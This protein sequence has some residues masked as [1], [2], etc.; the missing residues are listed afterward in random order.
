MAEAFVNKTFADA[1][2]AITSFKVTPTGGNEQPLGLLPNM[3]HAVGLGSSNGS[4][5][6]TNSAESPTAI[7]RSAI[8]PTSSMEVG[9][10]DIIQHAAQQSAPRR[11]PYKAPSSTGD[12]AAGFSYAKAVPPQWNLSRQKGAS[13]NNNK[14]PQI[15]TRNSTHKNGPDTSSEPEPA[16]T[17]PPITSISKTTDAPTDTPPTLN[18]SIATAEASVP[19]KTK[20]ES[21]PRESEPAMDHNSPS[22]KSFTIATTISQLSS[23]PT[24]ASPKHPERVAKDTVMQET[25][26]EQQP[27]QLPEIGVEQ[28]P[29]QLPHLTEAFSPPESGNRVAT[30]KQQVLN[31]PMRMPKPSTPKKPR[32]FKSRSKVTKSPR[33]SHV[34]NKARPR[35]DLDDLTS[36][37]AVT[38]EDLLQVLLTRYSCDKQ[39][40][41]QMRANHATEIHELETLSHSLWQRLQKC[42]QEAQD[43]ETELSG[44]RAREPKFNSQIKKLTNYVKGLTNDQHGLRDS[45]MTMQRMHSAV[46]ESKQEIVKSLE[47]VR[48]VVS[49]VDKRTVNA[50][51][52]ARQELS[53]LA[54]IVQDQESQLQKDAELLQYER[55]RSQRLEIEVGK[56]NT[57]QQH[58]MHTLAGHANLVS[59]NMKNVLVNLQEVQ[60]VRK[61]ESLDVVKIALGQ[62]LGLLDELRQ[63]SHVKPEHFSGFEDS[64]KAIAH[65]YVFPFRQRYIFPKML[66]GPALQIH[67]SLIMMT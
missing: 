18:R 63:A 65:G 33:H 53:N 12:L 45:F 20:A 44:F 13:Q 49:H 9:L 37:T 58:A 27:I 16:S 17:G 55:E 67:C 39:E 54:R 4:N 51:K 43:Q 19:E 7:P 32:G 8:A 3:P 15:D 60:A 22:P 52:D 40:R 50:L 57:S 61:P 11:F 56:I 21:I 47:D 41:E 64:M 62:C 26:M 66:I 5:S 1:V 46:H 14:V 6:R 24:V 38:E 29:I 25:G 28:Q 42:Q 35:I 34:P 23:H 31:R 36:K 30:P 10:G 59:E 2:T 48:G